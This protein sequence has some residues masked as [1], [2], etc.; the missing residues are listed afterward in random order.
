MQRHMAAVF[1]VTIIFLATTGLA[2]A[3]PIYMPMTASDFSSLLGGPAVPVGV[4][5][6]S[7]INAY[8]V[9]AEEVSQAFTDNQGHYAYLYQ[10]VNSGGAGNASL[11]EFSMSP[12]LGATSSVEL[13]YLTANI[14]T[15]FTVGNRIPAWAN[16]D[17]DAGPTLSFAFPGPNPFIPAGEFILP[18]QASAT[19]YLLSNNPPGNITGNVINGAAHA[20]AVVGPVPEPTTLSLL[21]AGGLALLA[22]AWR[23]RKTT[24]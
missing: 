9:K 19:L 22:C 18:G 17:A 10:I 1:I 5:T 2:I 7:D 13:G 20:G 15:Y 12:I 24:A 21:G 3:E 23:R 11:D 4:P 14:P 6:V 8:P 16:L